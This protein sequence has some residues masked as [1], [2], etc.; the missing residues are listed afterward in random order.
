M[1]CKIFVN[2]FS[3]LSP[4]LNVRAS[5]SVDVKSC[6]IEKKNP[7]FY[8]FWQQKKNTHIS[9]YKTVYKCTSATVTVHICTVTVAL[10]FYILL[11]LSL[12]FTSLSF[13]LGPS[14]SYLTLATIDHHSSWKKKKM[15]PPNQQQYKYIYIC[16]LNHQCIKI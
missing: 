3:H 6:K 14:H 10:A 9:G 12:S 7:S 13:S 11:I 5:A 15:Q 1:S 16:W 8:T 4:Y 2:Y